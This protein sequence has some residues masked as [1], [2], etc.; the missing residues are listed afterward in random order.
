MTKFRKNVKKYFGAFSI[1]LVSAIVS[2]GPVMAGMQET[3]A[4]MIV[5]QYMQALMQGDTIA[6]QG[7]LSEDYLKTK[8]STFENPNYAQFLQKIYVNAN[9]KILAINPQNKGMLGVDV[10]V[11]YPGQESSNFSLWLKDQGKGLRIFME[12]ELNN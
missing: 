8:K 12:T 7:S 4:A 2:Q 11:S 3:E 5:D 1:L 6:L 10:S 9:Y